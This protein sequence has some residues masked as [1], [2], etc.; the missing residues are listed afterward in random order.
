MANSLSFFMIVVSNSGLTFKF[1]FKYCINN[2]ITANCNLTCLHQKIKAPDLLISGVGPPFPP[3][4]PAGTSRPRGACW[5]RFRRRSTWRPW[6]WRR[7]R[8]MRRWWSS[9]NWRILTRTEK[10]RFEFRKIGV[11][12]VSANF[13]DVVF[14]LTFS[15]RGE[16]DWNLWCWLCL[17]FLQLW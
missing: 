17:L 7:A 13:K 11:W 1:K 2:Y 15:F 3:P 12:K 4:V 8:G 5:R 10:N 9:Y 6:P 16:I 14:H